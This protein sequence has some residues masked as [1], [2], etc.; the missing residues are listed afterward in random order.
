MTY[1]L[2]MAKPVPTMS[3]IVYVSQSALE[4]Y[5][6][7]FGFD[8]NNRNMLHICWHHGNTK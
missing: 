8:Y 6:S 1:D 7:S 2:L 5:H 4:L 3:L